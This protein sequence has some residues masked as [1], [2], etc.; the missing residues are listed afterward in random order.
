[1]NAQ[2]WS[3]ISPRARTDLEQ[4]A[5]APTAGSLGAALRRREDEHQLTVWF[6]FQHASRLGH[7]MTSRQDR[8]ARAAARSH[9]D[10]GV[11]LLPRQQL[12]V[13]RELMNCG[14][15]SSRRATSLMALVRFVAWMSRT[16]RLGSAAG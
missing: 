6:G 11:E 14:R 7:A 4:T 12:G 9:C 15:P 10:A 3:L 16:M 2:A 5:G 13:G 1:M 8:S